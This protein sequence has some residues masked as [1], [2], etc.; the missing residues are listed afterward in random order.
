MDKA[1]G[2][3]TDYMQCS[4]TAR[5]IWDDTEEPSMNEELLEGKG[6]RRVLTTNLQ[7]WIHEFVINNAKILEDYME[8]ALE[9]NIRFIV[10]TTK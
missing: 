5:R 2:F 3:C 4:V 10:T 1:L 9:H 6:S 8:K 7:H